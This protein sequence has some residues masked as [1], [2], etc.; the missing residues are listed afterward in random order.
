MVRPEP[1][2]VSVHLVDLI[3]ADADADMVLSMLFCQLA[4]AHTLREIS[5]GLAT[6]MGK[7]VHLGMKNVSEISQDEY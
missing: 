6:A 1:E 3:A 7:L 4:A 5:G 2:I